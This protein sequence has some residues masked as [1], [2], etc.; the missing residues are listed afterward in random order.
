[1]SFTNIENLTTFGYIP[2]EIL[3]LKY[4]RSLY[5]VVSKNKAKV[6]LRSPRAQISPENGAGGGE[7][8][9]DE[10]QYPG[11]GQLQKHLTLMSPKLE[12]SIWSHDTGQPTP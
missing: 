6:L 12:S 7:Q 9:Q 3:G 5:L 10:S 2:M 1:M 8:R 4:W 11:S